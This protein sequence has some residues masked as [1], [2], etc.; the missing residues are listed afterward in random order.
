MNGYSWGTSSGGLPIQVSLA[1]S[2]EKIDAETTPDQSI[3]GKK[4]KRPFGVNGV[5]RR[6]SSHF[7]PS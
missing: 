7:F 4:G 6:A 1:A 2:Y 5:I 3:G